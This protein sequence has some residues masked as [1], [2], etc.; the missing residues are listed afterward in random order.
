[1]QFHAIGTIRTPY[2]TEAPY[3][4]VR[5]DKGEFKII[6]NEDLVSG[7]QGLEKFHYIYV[8]YYLDRV[9]T[10]PPLTLVN[11]PW[12]E[13]VQVGLFASR[14][15]HRPNPIGVSI[16]A[17]KKI[18]HNILYTS[19]LD[20]YDQT[21]LLDIKPYIQDLDSKQDANLGWLN[22]N[23]REDREHLLLHIKGKPH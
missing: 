20:V 21:P 12:A 14:A 17:L 7:L 6:L 18:D 8:I 13:D 22:F 3:Q 1:M 16:V 5:E 10:G 15:P 9:P 4:P 2:L 11:P 23:N 19:G